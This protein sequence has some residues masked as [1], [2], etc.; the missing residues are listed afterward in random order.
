MSKPTS[1]KGSCVTRELKD[2]FMIDIEVLRRNHRP[3]QITT[4][5]VGESPPYSGKFFFKENSLPSPGI[6][7]FL[8]SDLVDRAQ[9]QIVQKEAPG[10]ELLKKVRGFAEV[11]LEGFLRGG[12]EQEACHRSRGESR[13]T[14]PTQLW[15]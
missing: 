3:Q 14:N 2:H 11:F 1:T 12:I 9:D 15:F 6:L 5:F 4:L 13:I 10:L 8:V 7:L